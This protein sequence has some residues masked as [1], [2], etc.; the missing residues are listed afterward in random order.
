MRLGFKEHERHWKQGKIRCV[1]IS[2]VPICSGR[3]LHTESDVTRCQGVGF[4]FFFLECSEAQQQ[5][6]RMQV[7]SF[8]FK[9]YL[10][11]YQMFHYPF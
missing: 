7:L 10:E 2:D 8:I 5:E 3:R 11:N 9:L 4:F 1:R 6:Q